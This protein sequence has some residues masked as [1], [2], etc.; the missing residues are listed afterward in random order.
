MPYPF[1]G[2]GLYV[3]ADAVCEERA[4]SEAIAGGAVVVQYRAKSKPSEE[5]RQQA[6]LLVRVCHR[7]AVPFIVNDDPELARTVGAD[8]VH[9][10]RSDAPYAIAREV[11]GPAAIIGVSCYDDL[12]RASE[13]A[14][15]GADYVAFG[16]FYPSASKP[17]A[18]RA[19]PALLHGARRRR[20]SIP[21]VAIGGITPENGGRLIGAGADLLAVIRGV[22]GGCDHR[23]ADPRAAA[24]RYAGLFE[25]DHPEN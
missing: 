24:R 18:V 22:F 23:D 9:L 7:L 14:A 4:V 5:R 8:G 12:D 25:A 19:E 3:I 2:R 21:V 1:P 15:A 6:L 16:S 10:G 13:A 17:D 20:L 11:L